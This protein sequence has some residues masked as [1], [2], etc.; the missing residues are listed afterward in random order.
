[1]TGKNN[2]QV[3]KHLAFGIEILYSSL[4]S[5]GE[6]QSFCLDVYEITGNVIFTLFDW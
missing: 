1:M 6:M 4:P 3:H 5:K 2:R